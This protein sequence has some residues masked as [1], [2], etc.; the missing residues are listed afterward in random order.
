MLSVIMLNVI[1]LSVIMLNVFMLNVVKLSVNMLS[2]LA[3]G[4]V[5]EQVAN[6]LVIIRECFLRANICNQSKSK[7]NKIKLFLFLQICSV[8]YFRAI[9]CDLRAYFHITRGLI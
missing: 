8:C 6:F 3:L 4:A 7:H 2:A 5:V 9:L 1:V